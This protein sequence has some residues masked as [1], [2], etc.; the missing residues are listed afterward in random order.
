[1]DVLKKL[2]IKA[3]KMM[4]EYKFE[5]YS[6]EEEVKGN[7]FYFNYFFEGNSKYSQTHIIKA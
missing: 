3:L 5:V 6:S 4:K 1:M 2:L 7:N